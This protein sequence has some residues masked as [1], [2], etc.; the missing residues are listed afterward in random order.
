MIKQNLILTI[1]LSIIILSLILIFIP[2][3]NNDNDIS[4]NENNNNN[5]MENKMT[6][7]K[8]TSTTNTYLNSDKSKPENIDSA[9]VAGGCFWC[10]E[11]SIE[12]VNGIISVESGYTGG[13]TKNPTYEQVTGGQTGHYEAVE[14]KYDKSVIDYKT[15]L[16]KFFKLFDPTDDTGSFAD[17]GSQY[18]S[19]IFYKNEVEKNIA[20]QLI[21]ELENSKIY[22]KP[23]VTKLIQNDTFYTAEEYHQ[24]YY[25]KKEFRY[26]QYKKYSGRV[27]YFEKM[28]YDDNDK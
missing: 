22:D 17:K 4:N 16:N 2:N 12:Q 24:D 13:H 19:A 6:Q 1:I 27:Q 5:K 21:K 3:Y 11:A 26:K 28:N 23:I 18:K 7:T 14:I 20:S 25:L 8:T 9:I 15:I 10:I